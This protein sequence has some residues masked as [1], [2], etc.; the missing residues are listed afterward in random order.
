M[1]TKKAKSNSSI[2]NSQMSNKGGFTLVELLVVI[3]ILSIIAG[4]SSSIFL[5]VIRSNNKTNIINEIQQNGNVILQTLEGSLRNARSITVPS[6]IGSNS[7]TLTYLDKDNVTVS[8]RF[9]AGALQKQVGINWE[10]ISN[11][12]STTGVYIDPTNSYFQLLS[13]SPQSLKIVLIIRQGQTAPGRI[14]YQAST[15]FQTTVS[16]RDY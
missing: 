16:L 10:N 15:T 2:L 8:Y 5:S 11:S 12:N 3:V 1:I 9:S 14:D 6:I 13:T 4:V 7:Q